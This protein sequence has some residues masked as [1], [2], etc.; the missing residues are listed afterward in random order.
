MWLHSMIL[1]IKDFCPIQA[2]QATLDVLELMSRNRCLLDPSI[3]AL[4]TH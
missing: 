4:R 3:S 1:K 2:L